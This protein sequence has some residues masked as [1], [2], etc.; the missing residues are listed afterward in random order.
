[1]LLIKGIIEILQKADGEAA[2]SFNDFANILIDGRRLSSAT[3]SKRLGELVVAGA[4]KEV[5]TR[6]DKGRRIIAYR[7][8]QKGKRAIKLAVE[9]KKVFSDTENG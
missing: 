3:V 5:I 1:M 4:V 9:L 8:T 2:G 7:T 6:S